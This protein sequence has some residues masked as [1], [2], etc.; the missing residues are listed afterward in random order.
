MYCAPSLIMNMEIYNGPDCPAQ[1]GQNV[2]LNFNF[3]PT[4]T[5]KLLSGLTIG[6]TY[7]VRFRKDPN[8]ISNI[9]FTLQMR[10]IG[11]KETVASGAWTNPAIWNCGT[12]PVAGDSVIINTGHIVT[13]ATGFCKGLNIK[14]GATLSW[15]GLQNTGYCTINGTL[16]NAAGL[17]FLGVAVLNGTCN[18]TTGIASYGAGKGF[19]GTGKINISTASGNTPPQIDFMPSSILNI[20]EINFL[21]SATGAN[22]SITGN[23]NLTTF[24]MLAGTM[25]LLGN[26]T[27]PTL[28]LAGGHVNMAGIWNFNNINISGG[29]IEN[30]ATLN[31]TF[32]NMTVTGGSIIGVGDWV[33]D[34]LEMLGGSIA[35]TGNLVVNDNPFVWS[36][37][38]IGGVGNFIVNANTIINT[39]A[40]KTA[41][42]KNIT[43]KQ[44][45][46]WTGGIINSNAAILLDN[47]VMTASGGAGIGANP[48]SN[49]GTFSVITNPIQIGG[50][51]N[52]EGIVQCFSGK[53]DIYSSGT[54]SG[55]FDGNLGKIV[56][57]GGD[58]HLYA[59]FSFGNT[60]GVFLESTLYTYPK[61]Y[62]HSNLTTNKIDI[63]GGD[64]KS[65]GSANITVTGNFN[66]I[67]GSVTNE[68][69]IHIAGQMTWQTGTIGQFMG[70]FEEVTVGGF[71]SFNESSN[72]A[73]LDGK[74][75]SNRK[76]ILNGGGIFAN[77]PGGAIVNS[78][79]LY[80]GAILEIPIAKSLT[81]YGDNNNLNFTGSGKILNKGTIFCSSL[82]FLLVYCGLDNYGT[83]N[84][85]TNGIVGDFRGTCIQSGIINATGNP[86]YVSFTGSQTFFSPDL[87]GIGQYLFYDS[88]IELNGTALLKIVEFSNCNIHENGNL[89]V[90]N[91][92]TISNGTIIQNTGN[93]NV[94]GSF[95]W[96]NGQIGSTIGNTPGELTV[97]GLTNISGTGLKQISQKNMKFAGTV[98]WSGADFGMSNNANLT[99][100]ATSTFTANFPTGVANLGGSGT[101]TNH[102]HFQKSGG[103]I[104]TLNTGTTFTNSNT[105]FMTLGAGT[106]DVDGTL[107]NNGV[108]N[109][110]GFL[111]LQNGTMNNNGTFRPGASP[112]TITV[113]GN[114]VNNIYDF[115]ILGA[116]HDLIESNGLIS[117]GGTLNLAYLGGTIPAGT[118]PIVTCTGGA[119][120]RTGTFATLNFAPAFTGLATV[121]YDGMGAYLTTTAALPIELTGFRGY[122]K[123]TTNHFTW[124]TATELNTKT[125]TLER[126]ENGLDNWENVATRTGAGTKNSPSFYE[127]DDQN[128]LDEAYYRVKFE[129]FDGKTDVSSIILI[130]RKTASDGQF[131]IYPNPI[132]ADG[133]VLKIP[134]SSRD[135]DLKFEFF[136][137]AGRLIFSKNIAE[138]TAET[139]IFLE[140]EMPSGAYFLKISGENGVQVLSV[141]R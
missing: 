112:G 74:S 52:N 97:S 122:E 123:P 10:E 58:Q 81:C 35:N 8:N 46:T 83:I 101:I 96:L 68:G 53:I 110:N 66:L 111:D 5:S 78:I 114:Y 55:L 71:T 88:N 48:F 22:L 84:L 131:S 31:T 57:L 23:L 115:E 133:F 20:P 130:K 38:N 75:I 91:S 69:F 3:T 19:S 64:I 72:P 30:T 34:H 73:N 13:G 12:I 67:K 24:S 29:L 43:F 63:N 138:A 70:A 80:S 89:T 54:H 39:N 117:L 18:F 2:F 95:N 33:I 45:V 87:K 134:E 14:T 59:P 137:T 120:C 141:L 62:L 9:T 26:F 79:D 85:P 119:N 113:L 77:A 90:N 118:Y 124:Q 82:H 129:D 109:G 4:I 92:L 65:L 51:F 56:F 104:V 105:G 121:T 40:D 61:L 128:P 140:K 116:N 139:S 106:V 16:N 7:Y 125:H 94:L 1:A 17:S 15:N 127:A 102:G 44:P 93:V 86:S 25:N 50:V 60:C 132:R 41:T 136:D 99:V 76:F 36:G 107:N 49:Q 6:Q 103:G 37:G 47:T 108:I 98:N 28:N 126:S 135:Q 27:L 100:E 32:N 21:S 42:G 11:M